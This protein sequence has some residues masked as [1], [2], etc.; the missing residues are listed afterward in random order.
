MPENTQL[1]FEISDSVGRWSKGAVNQKAD[2][3][4]VQNMLRIAAM[5][6][7][8]PRLDPNSIDGS[9]N[10]NEQNSGTIKAIEAFQGRFMNAPDG[11]IGVGKRTWNELMTT[12]E[13]TADD[14][15]P[16]G[17]TGSVTDSSVTPP[18]DAQFFFPFDRLP[19]LNWTEDIRRF[20]ARRS[21]GARAH[22]ACDLYFP[23]GTIIHAITSGKVIR[24]PY[25]FYQGTYALEI[26]H[27]TFLARYGEIQQSTLVSVG[28]Q[29]SAG[30]R[31]AKVGNLTGMVNSMLHLELYDKSVQGP[32]TVTNNQTA[33]TASGVPYMRRKDL[34]DPTAKLNQWKNNLPT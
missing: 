11:V 34:I 24:G 28:D 25:P 10:H 33:R 26:D 17:G 30:Q 19:N 31:I 23:E 5:I 9:I 18:S 7:K 3:E 6:L 29:V 32:L 22:A 21:K 12:L 8:E 13:G 20:G 2:V 16:A 1:K 27:G 15:E 14:T 4:T